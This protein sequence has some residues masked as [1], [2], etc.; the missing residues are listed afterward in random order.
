MWAPN[1]TSSTWE[2]CSYIC[3]RYFSGCMKDPFQRKG[4][5]LPCPHPRP[6]K[7]TSDLPLVLQSGSGSREEEAR[8]PFRPCR[9]GFGEADLPPSFLVRI[10]S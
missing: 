4:L 3:T 9:T 1:P 7:V 5:L 6:P 8:A 2:L 10:Q